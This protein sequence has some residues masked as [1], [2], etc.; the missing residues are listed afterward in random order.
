MTL[1]PAVTSAM[2]SVILQYKP[3]IKALKEKGAQSA[4]WQESL[5]RLLYVL[6]GTGFITS[7]NWREAYKDIEAQT[8]L[9]RYINKASLSEVRRLFIYHVRMDRFC[10]G[11]LEYIASS[12]VLDCLLDR[13]AKLKPV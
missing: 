8:L 5:E 12:G 3:D 9:P 2:V 7:F 13:L 4:E 11:H 6:Y 10:T 1:R